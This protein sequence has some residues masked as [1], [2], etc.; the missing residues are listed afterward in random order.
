MPGFQFASLDI[1]GHGWQN[2]LIVV[3]FFSDTY[4]HLYISRSSIIVQAD[5]IP[6]EHGMGHL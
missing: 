1:R 5:D 6:G 2:V 4:K 3:E